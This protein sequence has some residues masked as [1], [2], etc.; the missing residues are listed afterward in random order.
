MEDLHM[1]GKA[2][3][4]NSVEAVNDYENTLPLT[5]YARNL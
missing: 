3:F 2:T 4:E 1:K 5:T